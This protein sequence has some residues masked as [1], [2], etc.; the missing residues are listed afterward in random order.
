M[1]DN[2]EIM[3]ILNKLIAQYEVGTYGKGEE[4]L[5]DIAKKKSLAST[6]QSLVSSGLANTTMGAGAGQKWEEQVGMP[7]RLNLERQRKTGLSGALAA[8][9]GYLQQTE[10]ENKR[11][12]AEKERTDAY[13]KSQN[14]SDLVRAHT[15]RLG[16]GGGAGDKDRAWWDNPYDAPGASGWQKRLKN[17]IFSTRTDVAQAKGLVK[18]TRYN[19]SY[20]KDES[21]YG[22]IETDPQTGKDL[23]R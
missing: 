15:A 7:S 3:K 14:F 12:T 1:A 9:A 8:K 16:G 11:Y 20:R 2:S 4:A 19:R 23:W 18:K 21:G 17:P 6:S 10:S 5:L 13:T 22:F